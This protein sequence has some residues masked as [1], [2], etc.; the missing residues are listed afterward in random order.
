MG[1]LVA[2]A[3]LTLVVTAVVFGARRLSPVSDSEFQA[4]GLWVR[5]FHRDGA[6]RGI[7]WLRR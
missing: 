4:G 3:S 1:V 2:D 7:G 6:G 5:R